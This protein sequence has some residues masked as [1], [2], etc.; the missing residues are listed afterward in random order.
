MIRNS[1]LKSYSKHMRKLIFLFFII[2]IT[3]MFGQDPRRFDEDI[4]RFN[5]MPVPEVDKLVV[6][7][8]SSSIRFWKEA[9]TDCRNFTVVNTGFGG[10]QMSDLLYFID[11]TILRFNPTEVYIYEGDND[12]NAGKKPQD[13]LETAIQVTEKILEL[14][15][16]IN[17]HFIGAKPSPS[18]WELEDKYII[19]NKLLKYYCENHPQLFYI[20][21]WNP[22]LDERGRPNPQIFV[23]DSLH[24]NRKGYLL[25]KEV[26][27]KETD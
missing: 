6:F 2:P 3:S 15:K 9:D 13:I 14:N 8:G 23:E 22:M 18:R 12:I 26:I 16:E 24:M 17:I 11:E 5:S 10:S 1:N 19:F 27:C 7:T 20:D 4:Q 25:W 21:V